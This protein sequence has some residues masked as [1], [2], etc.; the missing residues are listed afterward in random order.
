MENQLSLRL[1]RWHC[2][3]SQHL[4]DFHLTLLD[5]AAAAVVSTHVADCV[6]CQA[7]LSELSVF[8]AS[9]ATAPSVP[10]PRV[11]RA[12]RARPSLG[13]ILARLLPSAPALA[14][15]GE[16]R[17]PFMAQAGD[18]LIVVDVQAAGPV[19]FTLIGQLAAPNQDQWTG[20]LVLVRR[21]GEVLQ[22]TTVDDLG[23]FRLAAVNPGTLALRIAP[24]QGAAIRLPE[25]DI[26]DQGQ[27]GLHAS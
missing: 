20:A 17:A 19:G 21:A 18:V 14:L 2:P 16:V 11:P 24:P 3:P 26:G 23:S 9:E 5:P 10:Q 6:R 7:E 4:T 22:T 27:W 15:R 8:L 12:S 13:E 1:H 25:I